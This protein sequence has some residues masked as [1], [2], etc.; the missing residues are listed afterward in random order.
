MVRIDRASAHQSATRLQLWCACGLAA[1]VACGSTARVRTNADQPPARS[2]SAVRPPGGD[3]RALLWMRLD[4]QSSMLPAARPQEL[5]RLTAGGAD[6]CGSAAKAFS[7]CGL[8]ARAHIRVRLERTSASLMRPVCKSAHTD[9]ARPPPV[10]GLTATTQL[11]MRPKG[12]SV[13]RLGRGRYVLEA[14]RP[15]SLLWFDRKG[16]HRCG[17][18]AR[19]CSVC[20]SA[21][22]MRLHRKNAS[23][24]RIDRKS[25][26]LMRLDRKSASLMRID[27]RIAKAL[28]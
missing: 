22:L 7:V 28:L 3:R 4:R 11:W 26:S 5:E 21:S 27:R 1:R 16:T 14:V 8:S 23:L 17:L 25:A 15:L 6:Q 20:A 9:A 18:T 2:Y 24:M 19:A 10:C 13:S 12:K